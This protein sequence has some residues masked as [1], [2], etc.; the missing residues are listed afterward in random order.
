[1][2]TFKSLFFNTLIFFNNSVLSKKLQSETGVSNYAKNLSSIFDTN[3]DIKCIS[4]DLSKKLNLRNLFEPS[5]FRFWL[6]AQKSKTPDVLHNPWFAKWPEWSRDDKQWRRCLTVHDLIAWKHPEWFPSEVAG[7]KR[8]WSNWIKQSNFLICDSVATKNDL[9]ELFPEVSENQTAVVYLG[10]SLKDGSHDTVKLSNHSAQLPSALLGREYLLSVCTIEPRKNLG[11]LLL[12]FK[13]FKEITKSDCLLAL[14]GGTGWLQ[15]INDLLR[16][17]GKVSLDVVVT[18]YVPNEMLPSLYK[19]AL[20]FLYPSL[21]EGFGLPVLDAM[22]MGVP[23][24]TSN[25]SSLPEITGASAL[26]VNPFNTDEIAAALCTI[27]SNSQLHKDLSAAGLERSK[28]FSWE[29]CATE[30]LQA[31][32]KALAM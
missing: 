3:R 29:R 8:R 17:L 25:V 26:L 13:K 21:Y 15:D 5:F 2:L 24:M 19:N 31:Y 1:M 6:Y 32:D 30:T 23:V 12:A 22:S 11:R 20:A 14:V 9:L 16:P 18:G 10:P 4:A 27:Y 28:L 7:Y